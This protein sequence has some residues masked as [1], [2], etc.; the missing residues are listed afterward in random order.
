MQVNTEE[1]I[2]QPIIADKEYVQ[3][4]LDDVIVRDSKAYHFVSTCNW[5]FPDFK[6]VIHKIDT[7][8]P[9]LFVKELGKKDGQEHH[10]LYFH[11]PK[12]INTVKKYLKSCNFINL[13]HSDPDSDKYALYNKKNYI[14]NLGCILYLLKG[15][16]NH[17]TVRDDFDVLPDISLTNIDDTTTYR[18]MY[19]EQINSMREKRDIILKDKIDKKEKKSEEELF[20]FF[21]FIEDQLHIDLPDLIGTF[22]LE[23][24]HII[25]SEHKG[26]SFYKSAIKKHFPDRYRRFVID[27]IH[28]KLKQLTD[29]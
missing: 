15:K 8:K 11:S 6:G 28:K 27:S 13:K 4:V 19:K 1:L 2:D 7:K 20:Q 16:T 26:F 24:P 18:E 29:L 21:D 14:N 17:F 3:S 25:H 10:H 9:Y 5:D 12:S 22:F 23:N